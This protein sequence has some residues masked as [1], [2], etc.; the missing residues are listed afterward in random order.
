MSLREPVQRHRVKDVRGGPLAVSYVCTGVQAHPLPVQ[1]QQELEDL[2]SPQRVGKNSSSGRF[3]VK[4]SRLVASSPGQ[5]STLFF[6]WCPPR[7]CLSGL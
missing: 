5:E 3:K 4:V 7:L 2:G 6:E 1:T